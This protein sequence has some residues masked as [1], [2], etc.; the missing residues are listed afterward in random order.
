MSI[1]NF[2][3]VSTDAKANSIDDKEVKRRSSKGSIWGQELVEKEFESTKDF[4]V[5][6]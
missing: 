2:F 6:I 3:Q 1:V 5:K 4:E